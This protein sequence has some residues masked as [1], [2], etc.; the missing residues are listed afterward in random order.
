MQSNSIPT[1][2]KLANIITE[3]VDTI[4]RA[5]AR[6][7]VDL[8]ALEVPFNAADPAEALR[9]DPVVSAATMELMAATSQIAATVCNPA[10]AILNASQ[11]VRLWK[12]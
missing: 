8:P 2:R 4:E 6:S 9:Q 11:S 12:V 5:Y 10:T 1:L 3:A 7:G